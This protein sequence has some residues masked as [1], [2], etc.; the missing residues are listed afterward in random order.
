MATFSSSPFEFLSEQIWQPL[1]GGNLDL[2]SGLGLR[3]V[4]LSGLRQR[5]PESYKVTRPLL[6]AL[7]C[8][9]PEN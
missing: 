9:I 2:L 7:Q 4:G 1:F 8:Q 6:Q 5:M 3:P